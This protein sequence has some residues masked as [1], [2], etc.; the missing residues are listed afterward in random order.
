MKKDV[1][2][3]IMSLMSKMGYEKMKKPI[4]MTMEM[5]S[6]ESPE[7]DE[8]KIDP[9]APSLEEGDDEEGDQAESLKERLMRRFG[10]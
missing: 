2:K 3:E 7:S 4:A 9:L 5:D 6:E 8:E 10:K 1:L